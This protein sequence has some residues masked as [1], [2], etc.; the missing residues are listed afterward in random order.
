MEPITNPGLK[1]T[2]EQLASLRQMAPSEVPQYVASD[3]Y[4]KSKVAVVAKRLDD[5]AGYVDAV[6]GKVKALG[7][8]LVAVVAVT[9]SVL[10]GLDARSA[11]HADAGD[12]ALV[13]ANKRQ[14]AR[15]EKLEDAMQRAA[16]VDVRQT[17]ML[18]Q[19]TE[20]ARLPVPPPVVMP[21][22]GR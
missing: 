9:A 1:L 17:V 5:E 16:Q 10:Y 11:G 3:E 18:E 22:G 6:L 20:K 8:L 12:A 13:E 15:I 14:D 21:D 7:G 2:P 19:L 4:V